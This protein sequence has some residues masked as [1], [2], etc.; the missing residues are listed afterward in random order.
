M[1]LKSR[2]KGAAIGAFV[3]GAGRGLRRA[4]AEASRV[5]RREARAVTFWHDPTDPWS[6]LLAQVVARLAA[7]YPVEWRFQVVGPPASDVVDDVG[8]RVAHAV[9]DCHDLAAHWDVD[10]P[11]NAR[12]LDPTT[13]RWVGSVLIR[14]RPF[15]DQLRAALELGAA[16]WKN[17]GRELQKV[18]GAWGHEG[19]VAVGGGLSAGYA[20][21][22]EAGHYTG[23]VLSYGGEHYPGI[24]R[25]GYLEARLAE[26]TG[27]TAGTG[28]L[29]R[30][31]DDARPPERLAPGA[32]V[33]LEVWWSFRSPYSYLALPRLADL[34]AR[35]P[36][37][38]KLRPVLPMVER[39]V[40]APSIKRL[41]LVQ[42]AAREAERLGVPFGRIADPL[43]KGVEH[44]L[45]IAHLAL[46][47]GDALPF[48]R[49]AAQGIWAEARDLADYVDLRFVVERA[50]LSWDDA[51]AAL[52][53][54]R[55]AA[56]RA[57]V[58]ANAEDLVTIG[59]WGVPSFRAGSYIT[60]GQ[61]RLD[62]LED[63]LRR[64]VAAPAGAAA[65]P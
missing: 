58:A 46:E 15:A 54:E 42:D 35:Y 52:A 62:F 27:V 24:D 55:E 51:R 12:P 50:G 3:G 19:H 2:I 13:A 49:S 45:A 29:Q 37:D 8:R 65:A 21:L 38:L 61:D 30:R 57:A 28:V 53:P 39:G 43:G 64:H 11:A 34:A 31:P 63:R 9:R 40:P 6:Y 14:E 44:A 22:R 33:P 47:R 4:V 60:W 23:G 25:V 16:S 32:R 48:L 17:D 26:D 41:F 1:T 18:V 5:V 56:W 20:A 7:R 10:F 59:L 36:I